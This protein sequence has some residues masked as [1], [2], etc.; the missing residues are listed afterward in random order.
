MYFFRATRPST[1]S[2]LREFINRLE[3]FLRRKLAL[4]HVRRILNLATTRTSQVAAV[5][6]LEHEHQRIL[7]LSVQLLLEDV[8]GYCPRLG[9]WY[10]HSFPCCI[11]VSDRYAQTEP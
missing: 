11:L 9:Y 1:I 2:S 10:R 6:R 7:L 4:Q 5:K 3:T 8:T